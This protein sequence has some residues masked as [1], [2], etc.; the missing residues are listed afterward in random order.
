M[1]YVCMMYMCVYDVCVCVY[2]ICLYDV[3]VSPPSQWLGLENSALL[4][5]LADQPSK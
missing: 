1:M 3:C 4:P 2:Y 5:H